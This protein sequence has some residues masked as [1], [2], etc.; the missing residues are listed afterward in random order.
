VTDPLGDV[1]NSIRVVRED[2][3]ALEAATATANAVLT[4][5]AGLAGIKRHR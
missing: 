1:A 5:H 4:N 3:D 2:L